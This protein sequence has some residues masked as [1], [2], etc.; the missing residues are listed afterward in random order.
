MK[1]YI[2]LD[3]TGTIIEQAGP[4]IEQMIYRVTTHSDFPSA[5]DALRFWFTELDRLEH[6][7]R[8]ASF[9]DE[10][11]LCL[12][13]LDLCAEKFGLREDH[14]A[15]HLLNQGLWRRG[16]VYPDAA[17]F[18]KTSRL[19][20]C[21]ITNNAA[22]Y[23]EENLQNNDLHP[24]HIV[25]AEDVRAYK[26]YPE[27]FE[28]ALEITGCTPDEVI[29]IGDSYTSDVLGANAAGIE[30]I[31]VDREGRFKGEAEGLRVLRSLEE[32]EA[33]EV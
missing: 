20:I 7:S 2:L 26:P 15:L 13:L 30:A 14:E 19:P 16:P 9:V 33:E 6:E 29:H 24:A 21:V 27:I 18:M 12:R 22:G 8:G 17:E 4:D 10:D 1:K 3:Y 5:R 31:L 23:V 28:R 11:T 25:S 32:V